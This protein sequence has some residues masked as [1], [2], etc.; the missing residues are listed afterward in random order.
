[1]FVVCVRAQEAAP[2]FICYYINMLCNNYIEIN[3]DGV[4]D[5]FCRTS[6]YS[7][8]RGIS[9][10]KI[11]MYVVV[12]TLKSLIINKLLYLKNY[13][14]QYQLVKIFFVFVQF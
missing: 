7:M 9:L 12:L 6:Q 14:K 11:I 8:P 1:V 2:R 4:I 13:P 3:S 10:I 5:I